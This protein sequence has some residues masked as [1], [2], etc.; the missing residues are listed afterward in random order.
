MPIKAVFDTN[1]WISALRNPGIPRK[2]VSGFQE[3]LV[4]IFCADALLAELIDV[5]QRPKFSKLIKEET[6]RLIKF[7]QKRAVFVEIQKQDYPTASPDPK[8]NMFLACAEISNADF[9]V[10]GDK[11]H[12]QVLGQYKLTKIVSPAQFL[13]ILK[14]SV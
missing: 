14:S 6:D 8:D 7:I 2:I 12:L 5:L 13:K 11:K 3:N 10:T 9:L 4:I 1:I